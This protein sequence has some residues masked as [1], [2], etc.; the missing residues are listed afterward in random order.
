MPVPEIL[1]ERTRQ[2][3]R[4]LGFFYT[5]D[6]HPRPA[7]RLV[8]SLA[9]L[10]AFHAILTTYVAH[11]SN[12]PLSEHEHYGPYT[13][14]KVMT[15]SE[16]GI[17]ADSIH[18]TL[19]DLTRLAD[20][21]RARAD[22]QSDTVFI[23]YDEVYGLGIEDTLHREPA[24]EKIGAAIGWRPTRSLDEVITDV[25]EHTRSALPSATL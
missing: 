3:W 2:Q 21:V 9:G 23:P 8:G 17:D 1:K 11:P 12:A 20:R 19:A 24:I 6:E 4:K 18:G 25:I 10:A 5:K 7:W 22:S 16:A 15:W 13:Y 14:L